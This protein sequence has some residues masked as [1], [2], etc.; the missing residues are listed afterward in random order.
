MEASKPRLFNPSQSARRVNP[1][2]NLPKTADG[3]SAHY[4]RAKL[5]NSDSLRPSNWNAEEGI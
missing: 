3:L 2:F 4:A 1:E 5:A